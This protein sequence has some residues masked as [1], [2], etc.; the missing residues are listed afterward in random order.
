MAIIGLAM[1]SSYVG[2]MQDDLSR[3]SKC[4]Y[5]TTIAG[6]CPCGNDLS[7]ETPNSLTWI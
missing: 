3:S 2:K 4:S 5:A 1:T 6:K 7:G